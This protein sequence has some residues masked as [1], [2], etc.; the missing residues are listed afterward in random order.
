MG[1]GALFLNALSYS[2]EL[3]ALKFNFE[4]RRVTQEYWR[5]WNE[6]IGRNTNNFVLTL[7]S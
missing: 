4:D 3:E 6:I 2:L 5:E 7:L 1:L